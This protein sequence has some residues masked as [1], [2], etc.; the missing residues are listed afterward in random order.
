MGG[1]KFDLKIQF[2][3]KKTNSINRWCGSFKFFLYMY[4]KTLLYR[5]VKTCTYLFN[6]YYLQYTNT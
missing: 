5:V 1:I 4:M 3:K 6:F 2:K